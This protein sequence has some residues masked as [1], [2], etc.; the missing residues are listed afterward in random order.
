MFAIRLRSFIGESPG[1]LCRA[2]RCGPR[3]AGR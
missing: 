3:V 1:R 2:F